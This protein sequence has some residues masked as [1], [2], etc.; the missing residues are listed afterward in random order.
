[1]AETDALIAD[2]QRERDAL[3]AMLDAVEPASMTTPG[4]LGE[5]SGREL[6][7][8]LGYWTGH[9]TEVIHLLEVGRITD[10]DLGGQTVDE[11]NATVARIARETPLATVRKREAASVEALVERLRT[12]DVALLLGG[13]SGRRDARG[14]DPRGRL[15]TLSR[16]CRG[17]A[18]VCS[19]SRRV[20][21][22][23]GLLRD[24]DAARE[25]FLEVLEDV[26]LEL[27]TVPGV[28]ED[29]SVRDLVYHVAVWC[30][31][32]SEAIDLAAH[33]RAASFAYSPGDT[34][35][36]N[37]RFLADG[38]AVS[39][40]DALA[41]EEGAFEGF[42]GTDRRPRRGVARSRARQRRH[43]RGGHRL[44]RAGALRESTR[45]HLRAWFEDRCG[46]RDRRGGCRADDATDPAA[47][48]AELRRTLDD[49][50]HR[51]HVLDAPTISD[52]EYDLL[53]KEL[54]EL[55]AA[56]P[57]L[58]TED[59]PTQRVGAPVEGGFPS[60][61]H[62]VP[63]LCLGNA[64]G[65]DELREFDARVRRGLGRGPDDPPVAYVCELKIDGLAI[66]LRYE[67]RAS[68]AARPAATARPART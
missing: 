50:N 21:D 7:A 10:D 11:I 65:D 16:A 8:H 32:G 68:S 1:M 23:S 5:W 22:R 58:V 51:Y 67:A 38:R 60:V 59:S 6:I 14:R 12:L 35:A 54:N 61:R 47:R 36:M 53:F 19:R 29:W 66:S 52:R 46:R 3:F 44:R 20:A 31:H 55:E 57:E 62:D 40:V 41:R 34:D 13:P 17:A 15:R 43:G 56:H 25:A 39:P 48:V 24:L 63:M 18:A 9:A 28:M 27:A 37:A 42:R 26:D 30:E 49:A 45:S 64:F 4:L 33:G 2:L